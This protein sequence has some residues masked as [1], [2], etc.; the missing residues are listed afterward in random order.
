MTD[1]DLTFTRINLNSVPQWTVSVNGSKIANVIERP[2]TFPRY[3]VS[4]VGVEDKCFA[5]RGEVVAY[6]ITLLEYELI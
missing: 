1:K 2:V 3:R 5:T 6:L 4:P